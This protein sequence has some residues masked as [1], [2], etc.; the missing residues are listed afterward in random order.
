M[1][2]TLI[3]LL[4]LFCITFAYADR[5]HDDDHGRKHRNM[6]SAEEMFKSMDQNQDGSITL[7][8]FKDV[9]KNYE[10]NHYY[11][12]REDH[13]GDHHSKWWKKRS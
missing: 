5:D 1:K 13:D 6:G 11:E 9:Y 7:S 8:E 12:D 2:K 4:S 3:I 10:N